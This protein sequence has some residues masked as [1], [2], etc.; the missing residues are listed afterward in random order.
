MIQKQERKLV[1]KSD[2]SF[3]S[4]LIFFLLVG[5]GGAGKTNLLVC[6]CYDMNISDAPLL[7][8]AGSSQSQKLNMS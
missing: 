8:H 4:S 1:L 6:Q 5:E 2:K 7:E 3:M